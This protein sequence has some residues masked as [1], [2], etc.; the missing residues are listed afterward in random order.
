MEVDFRFFARGGVLGG[1]SAILAFFLPRGILVE[2]A[3]HPLERKEPIL[4]F[5]K[6]DD[7]RCFQL[8]ILRHKKL[9][10]S[11]ITM[12]QETHFMNIEN[13]MILPWINI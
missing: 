6:Y 7:R 1:A 11:R 8:G 12:F 10:H 2:D 5:G 3:E 4:T 9:R 13:V